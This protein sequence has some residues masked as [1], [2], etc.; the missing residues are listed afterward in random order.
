VRGLET[1]CLS[2]PSERC[3][4]GLDPRGAVP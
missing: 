3:G 1:A 4:E 2:H